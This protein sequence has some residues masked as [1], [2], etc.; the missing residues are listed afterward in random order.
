MKIGYTLSS[1]EH[2]P[3][4]LVDLAA[5][6]EAAGFQF[7][8]ISDH[9]HPWV[10]RQGQSAFVWSTIGGVAC[11]TE[12]IP[13]AVGVTCP[14]LRIHPAVVAHA[15][16]TAAAMMPGRFSL[17]VGTG[18]RLNEHVLGQRWPA[19]EERR[20]MLEEAIEV[21]RRLWT[22]DSVDHRGEHF[23]VENARLHTC[24]ETPPPVVVSAFGPTSAEMAGRVGDGLWST[25]PSEE[26]VE[27]FERGGGDGPRYGQIT[28]CWAEDEAAAR[29]TAL[30]YWPNSAIPGQLAS[31]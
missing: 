1:E 24:P 17:G 14:I 25:A 5:D 16:A 29:R 26:L 23:T 6:A 18:E 30:E 8:T 11:S 28:M 12:R 3:R 31:E 13:L 7:L 27:A 4:R 22:G 2:P 10:S 9:F 20:E 21:M 15:A 19:I